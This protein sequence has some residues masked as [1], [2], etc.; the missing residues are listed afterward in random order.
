MLWS[1]G[2]KRAADA[3]QPNGRQNV[4]QLILGLDHLTEPVTENAAKPAA[5]ALPSDGRQKVEELISGMGHLSAR[6]RNQLK[7]KAK[8]QARGRE[9]AYVSR[10]EEGPAAKK[11]HASKTVVTEQPQDGNKASS[12]YEIA[13]S[14]QSTLPLWWL[15]LSLTRTRTRTTLRARGLSSASATA[16]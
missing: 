13:A 14:F 16:S 11:Q 9:A 15:R 10:E 3:L 2:V 5:D 12:G 8:A 6:E 1:E 4:E 7:R